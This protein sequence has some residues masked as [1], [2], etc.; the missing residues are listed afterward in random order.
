MLNLFEKYVLEQGR[1]ILRT[2]PVPFIM[3]LVV[4]GILIWFAMSWSYGMLLAGKDQQLA[5]LRDRISAWEEKTKTTTPNQAGQKIDDLEKQIKSITSNRWEPLSRDE[6]KI[7]HDQLSSMSIPKQKVQVLCAL[8][9][10]GDLAESFRL[11]FKSLNWNATVTPT[12]ADDTP[13]GLLLWYHDE[14]ARKIADAIEFAT[15][16]RLK[17]LTREFNADDQINLAIG[18]ITH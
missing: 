13:E 5:I 17:V 2:A 7:L 11:V 18:I 6:T 15:K 14:S 12:Y 1:L 9:G 8:A 3:S 10:C 4:I 16:G